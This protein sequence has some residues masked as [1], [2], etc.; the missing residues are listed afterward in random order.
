MEN[1]LEAMVTIWDNTSRVNKREQAFI[2][3]GNVINSKIDYMVKN[4][5]HLKVFC[6][7]TFKN[8]GQSLKDV[9]KR[10]YAIF[11]LD[12]KPPVIEGM[13]AKEVKAKMREDR[14]GQEQ[15]K[16]NSVLTTI[17]DKMMNEFDICLS[18]ISPS[19]DGIK[20]IVNIEKCNIQDE[21]NYKAFYKEY[22]T[23]IDRFLVDNSYDDMLD[24]DKTNDS[25]RLC[26]YKGSD[27]A[28]CRDKVFYTSYIN[29]PVEELE[30]AKK[31]V[32]TSDK[33]PINKQVD[34][35]S[36]LNIIDDAMS[37]VVNYYRLS[38]F[39]E[40]PFCKGESSSGTTFRLINDRL[41]RGV[42]KCH[43]TGCELYGDAIDLSVL[44]ELFKDNINKD[45]VLLREDYKQN[46]YRLI[47]IY[48]DRINEQLGIELI[49]DD[50]VQVLTNAIEDDFMGDL[51]Q[52]CLR[53]CV[54][55][56][57]DKH[58][59]LYGIPA[60]YYRTTNGEPEYYTIDVDSQKEKKFSRLVFKDNLFKYIKRVSDIDADKKVIDFLFGRIGIQ[61]SRITRHDVK[62]SSYIR[63]LDGGMNLRHTWAIDVKRAGELKELKDGLTVFKGSSNCKEDYI[64]KHNIEDCI[65][66]D[67]K[68]LTTADK[69]DVNSR[70]MEYFDKVYCGDI[71]N[72]KE[73][74]AEYV[75]LFYAL[76]IFQLRYDAR[77]T[78]IFSGG[79]G[80]GKGF[81]T[82]MF[83]D[84]L[85]KDMT[86]KK[87]VGGKFE[88]E[89]RA[90]I[91]VIDEAEAVQGDDSPGK[92]NKD[93]CRNEE[94][95][96]QFK[97]KDRYNVLNANFLI[98]TSNK[99]PFKPEVNGASN[100]PYVIVNYD[101]LRE[102]D[103]PVDVITAS[104]E[105][106]YKMSIN[107]FF[108]LYL[109]GFINDVIKPI[110][111]KMRGSSDRFGFNVEKLRAG[112]LI[113]EQCVKD[114][115]SNAFF[116]IEDTYRVIYEVSRGLSLDND[117]KYQEVGK[118]TKEQAE[119]VFKL[120]KDEGCIVLNYLS[121]SKMTSKALKSKSEWR[122]SEYGS[123]GRNR[124]ISSVGIKRCKHINKA[125][126]KY[127]LNNI[128]NID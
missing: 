107:Q 58:S 2:E 89:T 95:D 7:S 112:E 105:A 116:D 10:N 111:F 63:E 3:I 38:D 32:K 42:F 54:D 26:Y 17:I 109:G 61:L 51:V 86:A 79:A 64:I 46:K 87:A 56:D 122:T 62:E 80:V 9:D 6:G 55:F 41:G 30:K 67:Y 18:F 15:I 92:A 94:R 11:D 13:S 23:R 128:L 50:F 60:V 90:F 106:D 4:K 52:D 100:Y 97:G 28:R 115:Y 31:S 39:M 101:L 125:G 45:K 73:K 48:K 5:S 12:F 82:N 20:A 57:R 37:D 124:R 22:A 77:P 83:Y 65:T 59:K 114:D 74:N 44:M 99:V 19:G 29:K 33:Q 98:Y 49:K 34:P 84:V 35:P 25:T 71:E 36:T 66:D 24:V 81:F 108:R 75:K 53:C 127:L 120:F 118:L 96:I 113:E 70:F 68:Q 21:Y 103:K 27:G 104:I 126:I 72:D 91:V 121:D 88:S 43:H 8:G 117:Y 119:I 16:L 85:F 93:I 14:T 69:D 102:G 40:C 110:Y 47:G 1:S 78:L 123:E 76:S